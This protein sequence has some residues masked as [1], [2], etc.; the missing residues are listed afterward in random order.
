MNL[1]V[2]LLDED[3]SGN[4][5]DLSELVADS[6]IPADVPS[7]Q[8]SS[9]NINQT[10]AEMSYLEALDRLSSGDCFGAIDRLKEACNYA[11]ENQDY[12][13]KLNQLL[14]EEANAKKKELAKKQVSAKKSEEPPAEVLE[15][16]PAARS[17]RQPNTKT[18]Q[19]ITYEEASLV[20]KPKVSVVDKLVLAC[21]AMALIASG[22]YLAKKKD[23]IINVTLTSPVNEMRVERDNIEFFWEANASYFLLTIDSSSDR[24]LEIYT[25]ETHYKLT[26]SELAKLEPNTSYKWKVTPVDIKRDPLPSKTDEFWF[27]VVK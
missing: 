21:I 24:V 1:E 5:E 13:A 9:L 25:E 26:P 17:L 11:P 2:K 15:V 7:K 4:R 23:V 22:V 12:R 27:E 19:F 18:P 10:L 14:K 16:K 20:S 3:D 6:V 8:S